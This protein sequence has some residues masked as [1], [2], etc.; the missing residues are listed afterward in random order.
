MGTTGLTGAD[1]NQYGDDGDDSSSPGNH[2]QRDSSGN[3]ACFS[4]HRGTGQ[5]HQIQAI[6]AYRPL[7]P[8]RYTALDRSL[9]RSSDG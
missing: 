4:V 7:R 3:A 1:I 6:V 2:D 5:Y 8:Y 9:Y